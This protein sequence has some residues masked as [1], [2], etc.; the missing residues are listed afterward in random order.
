MN[1]LVINAGSSSIKYSLFDGQTWNLLL[2]ESLENIHPPSTNHHKAF[3]QIFSTL[4]KSIHFKNITVIA[5]RI[6]HGG[7][8]FTQPILIN[9]Q[10]LEKLHDTIP[11]APLHNPVNILGIK[12]SMGNF[13]GIP[14]IAV[15]DTA[16][17]ST[18][19]EY[20]YRYALPAKLQEDLGIRRFGFHGISHQY[21]T[22]VTALAMNHPLTSLKLISVHLGNGAS[23]AAVANGQCIDTSMGMTPLEGL[24]MGSRCG[25]L[26]P[27]IMLHLLRNGFDEESLAELLNHES[28]LKGIC[29]VSDMREVNQLARSGD[30]AAQLAITMFSYRIKKYIG[31]YTAALGGIDALIFTGGIGEHDAEI[32]ALCCNELGAL[33]TVLSKEENQHVVSPISRISA[34]QSRAAIFVVSTNEALEIAQQAKTLLDD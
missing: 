18:L 34:P 4:S 26:D 33:G 21:V 27:G 13:P 17:H 30:Q 19:P 3:E 31:A 7:A 12:F 10:V 5:H 6:V 28:G 2:E 24:M 11:L 9:S 20:A 23:I 25:D 1:I 16:F 15:F 29:G 14:N 32:R 8:K 22:K